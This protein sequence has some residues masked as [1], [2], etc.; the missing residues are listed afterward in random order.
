MSGYPTAVILTPDRQEIS[1]I[2]GGQ[3]LA[4][5]ADLL[6]LALDGVRPLPDVLATLSTPGNS[7]LSAA[8]CRRLAYNGWS[9]DPDVAPDALVETLLTAAERCPIGAVHERDRLAVAAV[10]L[11]ARAER[12]RIEAGET[13][14]ARLAGLLD[15]L[16]ALLAHRERSLATG[17]VLLSLPDDA[18]VIER[19]VRPSGVAALR[20]RWFALMDALEGD[21]RFAVST[22][23][24][25]AASRLEVAKALDADG[26]VPESVAQRSRATLDA[27]LAR[28]YDADAR[29]GVVNSASW[30][31]IQLGDDA[32]LRSLLE[33][34]LRASKTA[35]Y[36]LPDLAD[37]EE[38]AGR[39][40]EALALL[41]RGYREARG[42]ATRFQWGALYV[43]GLLRL[44]PRDEPRIRSAT[45][46]VIAELDGPDRIHARARS[47]LERLHASLDRWAR[48]TGH[49]ATLEVVG[50]RW[51]QL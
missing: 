39:P 14:S 45:L 5:Y 4:S 22:R 35:Y 38:R 31:L 30:V 48:E 21:E 15:V 42:T 36:Y 13:P 26:Q 23:L 17:D 43:D 8:D 1:R 50:R 18:F 10:D 6:D 46:A 3:D 49:G 28:D 12:P 41:E 33:A 9:L 19:L 29:S 24:M 27:F 40:T 51:A 25:S 44:S 34:Q 32:R 7:S 16:E 47:R 2:A 37:I 20:D 11:A